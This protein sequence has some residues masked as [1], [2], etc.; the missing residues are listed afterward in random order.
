MPPEQ[1][2]ADSPPKLAAF[3]R[4]QPDHV[5][6][7]GDRLLRLTACRGLPPR[8]LI[9]KSVKT[10]PPRREMAQLYANKHF[11]IEVVRGSSASRLRRTR[12]MIPARS[13]RSPSNQGPIKVYPAADS[14]IGPQFPL[15][16]RGR[17]ALVLE[18][19]MAARK[20]RT[21]STAR[22]QS[23]RHFPPCRHRF[24]Q[25]PGR[26]PP[27]LSPSCTRMAGV[28]DA[29]RVESRIVCLCLENLASAATSPPCATR[30][31]PSCRRPRPT[32]T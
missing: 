14:S 1:A 27:R 25:Q 30:P 23:S 2:G 22:S 13:F 5:N 15:R 24:G 18:L 26:L 6:R 32:P 21:L 4:K 19:A 9:G 17:G 29:R 31:L 10:G 20:N 11:P 12:A 16:R 3:A 28:P 7:F 8:R